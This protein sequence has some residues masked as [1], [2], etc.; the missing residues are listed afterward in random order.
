MSEPFFKTNLTTLYKGDAR[1]MSEIPDESIHVAVT[2]PPYW[3]LR[4]YEDLPDVVW[5]GDLDCQHEWTE[6][7][8]SN[9]PGIHSNN[10]QRP[11]HPYG[12]KGN[13]QTTQTRLG[14]GKYCSKC[15]A[16]SGSLGEEPTIDM[17]ARHTI[18]ILREIRRVLRKDGTLW[19]NSG[20]SHASGKGTCFNPGGGEDTYQGIIKY[21]EGGAYP[22]DRGNISDLRAMGLKPLDRCLI[23]FRLALAAQ[24]DGWY[25]RME[26]ILSKDNPMP[27][28]VSGVQW[29][30]HKVKQCPNCQAL[31]SFVKQVC[32]KCGYDN[33][34]NRGQ[35]PSRKSNP[36]KPQQDHEGHNFKP[37]VKWV[38]CPGCDKC[39]QND[40]LILKR[41]AGRP[42]ESHEYV[43]MLTKTDKY[44]YDTEAVR[45]KQTGNAHSRGTEK[46]NKAYQEARGSYKDFSSP[47]TEL[48]NG[49]NLR[50]VWTM[51]MQPF[52]KELKQYGQH[53]AAFP[54]RLAEICVQASTSEYG[55]CAK[56]GAP[57]ARVIEQ[58]EPPD[59][60]FTKT[61]NPDDTLVKGHRSNGSYRGSG[62]KY[63]EWL[64]LHPPRT[65]GWRPT[66][67]CKTQ[68]RIPA[69]VLDPFS[70]SGTSLQVAT[71]LG[72][73]SV[74]YEMSETYCNLIV[75]RCK[76]LGLDLI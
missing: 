71:K 14:T 56:C 39:S 44:Y 10:R 53:F 20:D 54:E 67:K 29:L 13:I 33:S 36:E 7:P 35:D 37:S 60:I 34:K 41:G 21:K 64:D 15:G 55:V 65:T 12:A 62:Q 73:A 49:R 18:E 48:P 59:E 47:Q 22:L 30:R 57:Y 61:N 17:Y 4:K 1:D 24:A 28:S 72:R 70:G 43:F 75:H 42:S 23:P 16:W 5:D 3:H 66:C 68:E 52:P 25:V 19:L 38:D 9:V 74:G 32:R 76:Q 45:E 46:G 6:L 50:S 8:K 40:G 2:S 31:D 58:E 51:P 26:I 63:Q 11:D 27:E 69:T